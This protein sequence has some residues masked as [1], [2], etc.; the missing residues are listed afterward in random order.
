MQ[1]GGVWGVAA[2][3]WALAL[4]FWAYA[5]VQKRAGRLTD[6]LLPYR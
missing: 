3:I 2:L 4:G 5:M 6:R 1:N